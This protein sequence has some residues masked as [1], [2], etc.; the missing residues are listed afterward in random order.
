MR[1]A[2]PEDAPQVAQAMQEC[3]YSHPYLLPG[4]QDRLMLPPLQYFCL[5]ALLQ[6][7]IIGVLE[8]V[9]LDNICYLFNLC[10]L[11]NARN[12]GIASDLMAIA[13]QVAVKIDIKQI[14]LTVL[15]NN[16]PAQKLYLKLGYCR[17]CQIIL[18]SNQILLMRKLLLP[19]NLK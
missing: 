3:F 4:L 19:K 18:N 17:L 1:L 14:Y 7:E 5:V 15:L 12:L 16:I 9:V 11:P 2:T 10:V 13:H 6:D 8:L